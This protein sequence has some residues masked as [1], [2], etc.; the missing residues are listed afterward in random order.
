MA[1]RAAGQDRDTA[2]RRHKLMQQRRTLPVHLG[3]QHRDAGRA[4]TG[5]GEAVGQSLGD[6][7]LADERHYDR[8]GRGCF[9]DRQDS[10]G[11]DGDDDIGLGGDRLARQLRHERRPANVR[12]QCQVA[13]DNEAKPG[14]LGQLQVPHLFERPL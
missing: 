6:W 14:K 10:H 2:R 4:A 1:R 3:C 11:R 9:L 12:R 8:H 5:P 13:A 7:V